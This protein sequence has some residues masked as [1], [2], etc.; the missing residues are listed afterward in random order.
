MRNDASE[1][2]YVAVTQFDG[3]VVGAIKGFDKSTCAV[4]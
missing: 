2:K 3:L 1:T 4:K